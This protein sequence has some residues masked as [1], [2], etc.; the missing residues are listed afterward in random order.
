MNLV[1][2]LLRSELAAEIV[3]NTAAEKL[4]KLLHARHLHRP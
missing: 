2:E 1:F 4:V 3:A